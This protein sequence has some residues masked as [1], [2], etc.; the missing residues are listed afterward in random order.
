MIKNHKDDEIVVG[1]IVVTLR[2]SNDIS[3]ISSII[4]SDDDIVEIDEIEDIELLLKDKDKII[5]I[6]NRKIREK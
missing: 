4:T 3:H 1:D 2:S 5:E 6:L